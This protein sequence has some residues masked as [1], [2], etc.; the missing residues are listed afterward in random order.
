M[1]KFDFIKQIK[2][3]IKLCLISLTF[4]IIIVL[5]FSLFSFD[6][7][8]I[9]TNLYLIFLGIVF[10]IT[11]ITILSIIGIIV[12]KIIKQKNTIK[13][14]MSNNTY[15]R[16]LSSDYGPAI[17]SILLDIDLEVYKDYTAT[18]INL[19]SKK[20]LKISKNNG[21]I[22]FEVLS[23]DLTKLLSHELYV[24]N[25]IVEKKEFNKEI[26]RTKV[27]NDALLLGLIQEKVSYKFW[28]IVPYY[29]FGF[30]ILAILQDF[31]SLLNIFATFFGLCFFPIIISCLIISVK[32]TKE[33][34]HRT[35]KGNYDAI[36]WKQF[37][38]FL[39][40]F[41]T[42]KEKP[43]EY[44]KLLDYY[45]AYA[46]SLGEAKEIEK[47]IGKDNEFRNLIYNYSIHE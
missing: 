32:R 38:N 12:V 13:L 6:I 11:F 33:N 42:I 34:Y 41:S 25:C 14:E 18:I 47:F 19:C 3:L 15:F 20:Y 46:I 10:L 45:L 26:F 2:F 39:K 44:V 1:D 7:K 43:I 28:L 36:K 8:L 37:K 35:K 40:D 29:L 22:L 5:F 21:L 17:A 31:I 27:V 4:I 24:Y 30:I 9:T 23:N 16:N